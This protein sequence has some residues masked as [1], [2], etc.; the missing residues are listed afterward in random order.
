VIIVE[1]QAKTRNQKELYEKPQIKKVHS[2]EHKRAHPYD[3]ITTSCS[4][5]C[6]GGC[7][8]GCCGGGL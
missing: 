1:K 5:S 7:C 3:M 8:C 6:C 2:I 4:C